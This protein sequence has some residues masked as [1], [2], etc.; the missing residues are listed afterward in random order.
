MYAGACVCVCLCRYR[1]EV[2]REEFQSAFASFCCVLSDAVVVFCCGGLEKKKVVVNG[3]FF[4][5]IIISFR[6]SKN[7]IPLRFF[8]CLFLS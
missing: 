7:S 1:A 3:A 4:F 8:F 6:F 5:I 2:F